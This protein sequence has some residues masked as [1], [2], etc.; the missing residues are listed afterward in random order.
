M[1]ASNSD[2]RHSILHALNDRC[3]QGPI[4]TSNSDAKHAVIHVQNDRSCLN[5]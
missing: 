3:D 5:P 1:E 2:A 4:E